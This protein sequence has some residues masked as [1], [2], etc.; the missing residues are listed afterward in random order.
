MNKRIV[1]VTEIEV[2]ALVLND[3]R[4]AKIEHSQVVAIAYEKEK[5][6]DFYN[7]NKVETYRDGQWAKSFAKGSPL[8]WYNTYS[9][10]NSCR[11]GINSAWLKED[12]ISRHIQNGIPIIQ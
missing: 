3:M 4:S 8:E 9:E 2:F 11:H 10:G 5:L 7:S 6:I 1:V 12:S